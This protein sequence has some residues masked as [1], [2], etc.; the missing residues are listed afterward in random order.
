[1]LNTTLQFFWPLMFPGIQ[2]GGKWTLASASH[3]GRNIAYKHCGGTAAN[4]SLSYICMCKIIIGIHWNSTQW[5]SAW[6]YYFQL[7]IRVP[8]TN[9]MQCVNGCLFSKSLD[10]SFLRVSECGQDVWCFGW[11]GFKHVLLSEMVH[12]FLHFILVF[13]IF[14]IFHFRVCVWTW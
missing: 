1:M 3:R 11:N 14:W 5:N 12:C 7:E 9:A 2:I 4:L 6:S 8:P 10:F 13:E